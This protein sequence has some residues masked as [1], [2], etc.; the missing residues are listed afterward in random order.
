MLY[1][2]INNG[3]YGLVIARKLIILYFQWVK[4]PL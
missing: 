3:G 1:A 2:N 4:E